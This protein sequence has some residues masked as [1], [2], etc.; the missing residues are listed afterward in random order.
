MQ[1]SARFSDV[2][3]NYKIKI[4]KYT[5]T[6][7][8]RHTLKIKSNDLVCWNYEMPGWFEYTKNQRKFCTKQNVSVEIE[9][10]R[11]WSREEKTK[12]TFVA[13]GIS[14]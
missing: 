10:E 1:F 2:P 4:G 7:L 5:Q 14:L 11:E 9:R 12:A 13:D 8:H 3:F 6:H